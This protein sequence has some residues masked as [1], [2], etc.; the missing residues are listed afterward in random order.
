MPLAFYFEVL[1]FYH[2]C[3]YEKHITTFLVRSG[4]VGS[5]DLGMGRASH[6]SFLSGISICYTPVKFH[7][8]RACA[9]LV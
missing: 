5:G 7:G 6:H 8:S 9:V 1:I 3:Y 4:T 2:T